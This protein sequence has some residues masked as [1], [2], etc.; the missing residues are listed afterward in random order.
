M[1]MVLVHELVGFSKVQRRGLE[2]PRRL[3]GTTTTLRIHLPPDVHVEPL[4]RRNGPWVRLFPGFAE[5]GLP[6]L[7]ADLTPT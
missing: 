6:R 1:A 2:T 4:P 5:L 7:G 3:L